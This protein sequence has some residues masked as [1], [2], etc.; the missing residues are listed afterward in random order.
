MPYFMACP[1]TTTFIVAIILFLAGIIELNFH[2]RDD[3]WLPYFVMQMLITTTM[4][5]EWKKFFTSLQMFAPMTIW[6]CSGGSALV[7]PIL[8]WALPDYYA[9]SAEAM[10]NMG[11]R[12]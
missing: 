9:R 8:R 3:A 10:M 11:V 7:H 1:S 2:N 6:T 5:I 12:W 4:F